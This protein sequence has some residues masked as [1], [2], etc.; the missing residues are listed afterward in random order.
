[1]IIST[2]KIGPNLNPSGLFQNVGHEK[3]QTQNMNFY[4]SATN[5]IDL[6]F[7]ASNV[8]FWMWYV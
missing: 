1:M 7:L 3:W 4:D 2:M 5:F 6:K 8:Y